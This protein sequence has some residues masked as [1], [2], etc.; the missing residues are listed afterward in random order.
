M[1]ETGERREGKMPSKVKK[2]SSLIL[3]N[4]AILVF[5]LLALEGAANVIL[6]VEQL[7]VPLRHP[8]A[9]RQHTRYDP[10][11]G[12][13]NIPNFFS[14]DLY[15]PGAYVRINSQGFRNEHD[16]AVDP[17]PGKMRVI[18]SGD[19]FTFGYGVAN[20]QTWCTLIETKSPMLETVNM[21]E[22]G[23]GIDQ[24]YLWY[25]RDARALHHRL[26]LFA[27]I[28]GDFVRMQSYNFEGYGKPL[29]IA[30]GKELKV[31]NV[32]VPRRSEFALLRLQA[33]AFAGGLAT[34]RLM[35]EFAQSATHKSQGP[36]QTNPQ[37]AQTTAAGIFTELAHLNQER[38][39][40]L[41][42]V[43]LPVENMNAG[44]IKLWREAVREIAA[45]NGIP[46]VDLNEDFQRLPAQERSQMFIPYGVL[47]YLAA[48]GH[49]S[50]K[51]NQFI[52]DR[53]YEHLTDLHVLSTGLGG[54]QSVL[55]VSNAQ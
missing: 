24:A 14:P 50:V 10:S 1:I 3:I 13:V 33:R 45:T 20:N 31:T 5:G 52:A 42:L 11:L 39:S 25:K 2:V 54:S 8:L 34:S 28:T 9:E 16:F 35:R 53:I 7:T 22:G 36:A 43:Y 48:A 47:N 26:Q 18:C 40:S 29:L 12:W 32:P 41:I 21:G 27:F 49:Y 4:G 55:R 6:L 30:Q 23:Y 19:S 51:G 17:P 46:L 15:G 44:G 38:G 37:T